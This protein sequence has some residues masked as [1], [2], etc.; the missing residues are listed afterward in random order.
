MPNT[1]YE[2]LRARGGSVSDQQ[3][4]NTILSTTDL[5][6]RSVADA[7]ERLRGI[8]ID[9]GKSTAITQD[10]FRLDDDFGRP[11]A[12][13]VHRARPCGRSRARTGSAS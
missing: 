2:Q 9:T 8:S 7:I 12:L 4:M 13:T 11:A 3:T 10:N 6:V 5:L 1:E